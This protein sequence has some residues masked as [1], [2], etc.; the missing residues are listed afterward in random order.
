MRMTYHGRWSSMNDS[1]GFHYSKNAR[2]PNYSTPKPKKLLN[3]S[4]SDIDY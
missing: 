4:Q 1:T 3:L 2:S